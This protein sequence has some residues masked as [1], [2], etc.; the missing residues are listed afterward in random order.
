MG[1]WLERR[2][3]LGAGRFSEGFVTSSLVFCVGPMTVVGSIQDGLT[4]NFELLATKSV[5]DGFAAL[6]FAATF[7]LGVMFSAITVFVLQGTLTLGA[8]VLQNVLSEPAILEM[9][10]VGGLARSC[11]YRLFLNGRWRKAG[12]RW[13][14][15]NTDLRT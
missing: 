12:W 8:T 9:E 3:A 13:C 6:A 1:D 7:G 2:F 14:R 11:M 5:L 10:A 15:L 4:G